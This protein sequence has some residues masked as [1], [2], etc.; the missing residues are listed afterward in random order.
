MEYGRNGPPLPLFKLKGAGPA[1]YYTPTFLSPEDRDSVALWPFVQHTVALWYMI[2]VR[3]SRIFS[4]KEQYFSLTTNQRTVLFSL[5]F[6]QS[7]A[8]RIILAAHSCVAS[9]GASAACYE[10]DLLP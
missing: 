4:A 5:T 3:L 1:A 7:K 9:L 10:L 8:N 6:E 2:S